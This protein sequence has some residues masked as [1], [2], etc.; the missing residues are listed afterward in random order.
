MV[1][2]GLVGNANYF[3]MLDFALGF[4]GIDLCGDDGALLGHW[5][6]QTVQEANDGAF[7]FEDMRRQFLEQP[8]SAPR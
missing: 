7:E 3:E 4:V 6:G 5:P 8:Q 1:H 2:V